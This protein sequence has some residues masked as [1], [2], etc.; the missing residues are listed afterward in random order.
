MKTMILSLIFLLSSCSPGLGV[1][2]VDLDAWKNIPVIA[3]DTHSFFMTVPMIKTITPDGLE[4]RIY[5]NSKSLTQCVESG[6]V[7]ANGYFDYASYSEYTTCSSNT[8]ACENIFYIKDGSVVEYVPVSKG[9]ARCFTNET[10]QPEP[11]YL[12]FI[13]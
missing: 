1:R 12:K 4:I 8:M 9:G 5:S 13:K 10:V 6:N 7:N 2:Q 3:L 11:R